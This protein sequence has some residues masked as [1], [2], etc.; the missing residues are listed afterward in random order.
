MVYVI[1]CEARQDYSAS[2]NARTEMDGDY[3]MLAGDY[4]MQEAGRTGAG[5]T[6]LGEKL[7]LKR[8]MAE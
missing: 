7:G 1:A 2:N 8:V 6:K 5:T 4:P 3:H